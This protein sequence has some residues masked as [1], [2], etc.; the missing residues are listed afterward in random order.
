MGATGFERK[1]PL[2]N[3][4]EWKKRQ[5]LFLLLSHGL[6]FWLS[7]DM[8]AKRESISLTQAE[9]KSLASFFSP[10]KITANLRK[11]RSW[12]ANRESPIVN[13]SRRQKAKSRRE[14][15]FATDGQCTFTAYPRVESIQDREKRERIEAQMPNPSAGTKRREFSNSA[16]IS[17]DHVSITEPHVVGSKKRSTPFLCIKGLLD[18]VRARVT[19]DAEVA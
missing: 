14:R 6:F 9:S 13:R 12:I 18:G 19:V 8:R 11:A 7:A 5:T 15:A 3:A 10:E 2:Q 1:D 17:S 16:Q 4:K